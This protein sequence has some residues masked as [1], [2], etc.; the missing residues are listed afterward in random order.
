MNVE[1][2][3]ELNVNAILIYCSSLLCAYD[4]LMVWFQRVKT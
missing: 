2:N 4:T 1:D 3:V